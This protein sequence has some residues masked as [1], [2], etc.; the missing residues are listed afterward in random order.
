MNKEVIIIGAG[1]HG[2]VIAD[3]VRRSGDTPLGF[4][5]DGEALPPEIAGIPLL[6]KVSDY[7]KYPDAKPDFIVGNLAEAVEKIDI[8]R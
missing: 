5:D 2:K 3:I 1:G 7:A 6:G 8:L 4:L